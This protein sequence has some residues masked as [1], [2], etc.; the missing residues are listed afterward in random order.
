V[1]LVLAIAIAAMV[2]AGDNTRR[3]EVQVGRYVAAL[4][5]GDER[6]ALIA[7]PPPRPTTTVKSAL[8][9]R[10]RVDVTRELVHAGVRSYRVKAVEW[11]R[12]CCEPGPIDD[13]RHAGLARISVELVTDTGTLDYTFDVRA[14][15]EDPNRFW[16]LQHWALRDVYP[17]TQ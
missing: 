5:H 7:W 3:P 11:W 4:V 1:K 17:P 10:R 15:R 6:A 12:T 14:E 16:E 8:Q 13:P 9:E 2:I